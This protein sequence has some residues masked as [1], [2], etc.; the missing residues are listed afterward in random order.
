MLRKR[1]TFR[2]GIAM[3]PDLY[4]IW[5]AIIVQQYLYSFLNLHLLAGPKE[6]L[7]FGAVTVKGSEGKKII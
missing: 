1:K 3:K 5:T 6:L 7:C 4:V 2:E